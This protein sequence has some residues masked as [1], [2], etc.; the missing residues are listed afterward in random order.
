MYLLLM[1]LFQLYSLIV[2]VNV[3]KTLLSAL[4]IRTDVARVLIQYC[5][6]KGAVKDFDNLEDKTWA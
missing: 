5:A 1:L 3:S 6:T 4:K 2:L